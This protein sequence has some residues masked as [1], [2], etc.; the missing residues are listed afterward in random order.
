MARIWK[1]LRSFTL[2]FNLNFKT[3][4]TGPEASKGCPIELEYFHRTFNSHTGTIIMTANNEIWEICEFGPPYSDRLTVRGVHFLPSLAVAVVKPTTTTTA[5]RTSKSK[6]VRYVTQIT[7]RSA[8][9]VSAAA[10]QKRNEINIKHIVRTYPENGFKVHVVNE[11]AWQMTRSLAHPS[12][13]SFQFDSFSF[14]SGAVRAYNLC[15]I[16]QMHTIAE[17]SARARDAL[18]YSLPSNNGFSCSDLMFCL[19][20]ASVLSASPPFRQFVRCT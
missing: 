8:V 18:T 20:T 4:E 1:I 10:E 2:A 19:R 12:N 7:V 15:K 13:V 16:Q 9:R 14:A 5:A 17:Q 3:N 6:Y 11:T